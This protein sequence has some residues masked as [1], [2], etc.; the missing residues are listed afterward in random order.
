MSLVTYSRTS[1]IEVVDQGSSVCVQQ[2]T[3]EPGVILHAP[4]VLIDKASCRICEV[5]GRN[6]AGHSARRAVLA[7]YPA[8][9]MP[10]K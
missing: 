10:L 7:T 8:E 4:G 5:S 2:F 3:D 6:W 1:G 9:R